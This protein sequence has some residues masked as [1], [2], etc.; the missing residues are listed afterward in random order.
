MHV[1][2]GYVAPKIY[3]LG[4][5]GVVRYK[6]LRIGGVSGIYDRHH[7]HLGTSNTIQ[8]YILSYINLC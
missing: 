1:L 3:F 6:G 7:Y 2:I 4:F 5:G 8:E